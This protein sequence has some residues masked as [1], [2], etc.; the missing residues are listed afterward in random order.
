MQYNYL[1]DISLRKW[2]EKGSPVGRLGN[3][4]GMRCT[5]PGTMKK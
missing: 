4:E 3:R 1:R 2:E 5:L